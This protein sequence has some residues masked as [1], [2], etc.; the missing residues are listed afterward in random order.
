MTEDI[1]EIII[2]VFS[3]AIYI[4]MALFAS[5]LDQH[6]SSHERKHILFCWSFGL[7]ILSRPIQYILDNMFWMLNLATL[8][9]FLFLS[10]CL[11]LGYF[12]LNIHEKKNHRS[13][14]I[15]GFILALMFAF[16]HGTF[17]YLR[18]ILDQSQFNFL[19]TWERGTLLHLSKSPIVI[20]AFSF[21]IVPW[22]KSALSNKTTMLGNSF[23]S[24]CVFLIFGNIYS[25]WWLFYCSSILCAIAW[26][27]VL[28]KKV[29]E[30]RFR[31]QKMGQLLADSCMNPLVQKS[32]DTNYISKSLN[33]MGADQT[34]RNITVL[35][36]HLNASDT[37]ANLTTALEENY[38][39]ACVIH[40][41][42]S[43]T[44]TGIYTGGVQDI[45]DY[46]SFI[47]LWL[48]SK[49]EGFSVGV[50]Q[51]THELN[52]INEVMSQ[53]AMLVTIA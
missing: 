3:G 31:S 12:A 13:V 23:F 6:G 14:F 52:E 33:L 42:I 39:N 53:A 24:L 44:F 30:K 34:P 20:G 36:H 35:H 51:A 38:P 46:S 45:D 9:G 32:I 22:I 18:V 26:T 50:G 27:N 48:D 5:R 2:P 29:D 19:G 8:R 40:F 21:L 47:E 4:W 7:F 37:I 43:N 10:L 41:E 49:G 1:K 25:E 16:F 28:L 15:W 11:P 17:T